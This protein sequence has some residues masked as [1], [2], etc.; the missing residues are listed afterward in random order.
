[1]AFSDLLDQYIHP[2]SES[3]ILIRFAIFIVLLI[4]IAALLEKSKLFKENRVIL[5]IVSFCIAAIASFYVQESHINYFML[6]PYKAVSMLFILII[7]IFILILLAKIP[8]MNGMVRKIVWI[9]YFVIY[10]TMWYKDYK[11]YSAWQ[12]QILIIY[13]IILLVIFVFERQVTQIVS[14]RFQK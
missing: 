1:M 3:Y 7:P 8:Y 5:G 11:T 10:G 12:N 9:I 13:S 6:Y 4:A 14:K 2:T